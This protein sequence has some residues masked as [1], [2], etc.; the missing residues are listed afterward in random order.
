MRRFSDRVTS[1]CRSL[2]QVELTREVR[3]L[4]DLNINPRLVTLEAAAGDQSGEA[5]LYVTAGLRSVADALDSLELA[6]EVCQVLF[7][8]ILVLRKTEVKHD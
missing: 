6:F 1:V 7:S 4:L 8:L 2:I 5:L 3:E